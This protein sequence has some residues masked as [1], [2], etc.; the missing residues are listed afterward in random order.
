MK[1]LYNFIKLKLLSLI[2]DKYKRSSKNIFHIISIHKS[3]I[4]YYVEGIPNY[5]LTFWRENGLHF[6]GFYSK[7]FEFHIEQFKYR[8]ELSKILQFIWK[9]DININYKNESNRYRFIFYTV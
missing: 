8:T 2:N 6:E 9:N 4:Q 7:T 3:F 5:M 1:R